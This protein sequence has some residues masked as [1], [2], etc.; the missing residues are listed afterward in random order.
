M[1]LVSYLMV[2]VKCRVKVKI[3]FLPCHLRLLSLRAMLFFAVVLSAIATAPV[4]SSAAPVL[5][6][7]FLGT[8]PFFCVLSLNLFTF[9]PQLVT[10]F[11]FA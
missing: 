6:F 10:L 3:F 11:F 4:Q 2:K 5:F 1:G 8:F 7:F 9:F